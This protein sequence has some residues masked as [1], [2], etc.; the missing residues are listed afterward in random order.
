M[1]TEGKMYVKSG[2]NLTPGHHLLIHDLGSKFGTFGVGKVNAGN[3]EEEAQEQQANAQR[4]AA[5]WNATIGLSTE[6]VQKLDC[7]GLLRALRA[8]KEYFELSGNTATG[9]P[10][11]DEAYKAVCAALSPFEEG[12]GGE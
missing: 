12:G 10:I 6:E 9:H 8:S 2:G 5:A 4:L 7:A 1:H 3:D 11:T